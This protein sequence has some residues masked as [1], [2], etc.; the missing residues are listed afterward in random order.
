MRRK[1]GPV[2]V[3]PSGAL[4][5]SRLVEAIETQHRIRVPYIDCKQH[6]L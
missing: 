2:A 6:D 1:V 3:W 4:S 5:R